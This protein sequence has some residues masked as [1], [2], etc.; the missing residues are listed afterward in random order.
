MSQTALLCWTDNKNRSVYCFIL[1]YEPS[2]DNN[3]PH[4]NVYWQMI[5][6][7]L[8]HLYYL[9][10]HGYSGMQFRV[11]LVFSRAYYM[12]LASPGIVLLSVGNYLQTCLHK[13]KPPGRNSPRSK[14]WFSKIL[15]YCRQE[16]ED[17]PRL[18][19]EDRCFLFFPKHSHGMLSAS[20]VKCDP[21]R[22]ITLIHYDDV[23][24]GAIASQITCL[25]IVYSTVY[26][27]ADQRKHQ[28]SA[29]L[30]YVRGINWGPVNSPHKWP[31]TRKMF[32]FDDVIMN[33]FYFNMIAVES[34]TSLS[35]RAPERICS[36]II[37]DSW[38]HLLQIL[39]DIP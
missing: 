24:M 27:G 35:Y 17:P 4:S 36:L 34:H 9:S 25:T 38:Q 5:F 30:A 14:E 10:T 19:F 15:L 23:I 28:S 32:P 22:R 33:L 21:G 6:L 7:H 16:C 20:L 18:L 2:Q 13:S 37:T 1:Y 8:I 39:H 12:R 11:L 26:S 29:S 31:V 3:D